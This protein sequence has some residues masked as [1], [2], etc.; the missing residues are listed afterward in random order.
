[1]RRVS[2]EDAALMIG[3]ALDAGIN[4]I[5]AGTRADGE[6]ELAA[7]LA[8]RR[9]EFFLATKTAAINPS[10]FWKDLDASL[11]TFKTDCIDLYQICELSFIP[12]PEDGSG[13]YEAMQ[14]A[15]HQGKLRF[16]GVACDSL[17]LAREAVESGLYDTLQFAFD[18][19][20][21]ERVFELAACCVENRV[22]FMAARA[23]HDGPP[24]DVL[25]ER[26]FMAGF[27]NAAQVWSL[28]RVEELNALIDAMRRPAES[29][30][31]RL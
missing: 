16:L 11:R 18:R 29:N 15:Q 8:H 17:D 10:V 19:I 26:A 9:S 5:D 24:A 27:A 4:L 2:A 3:K 1:L 25:A 12:R 20:S 22:G 23:A 28:R 7:A 13:L 6:E 21:A 14:M 30:D 31:G